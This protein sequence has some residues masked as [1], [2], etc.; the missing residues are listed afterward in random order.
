VLEQLIVVLEQLIEEGSGSGWRAGVC[1]LAEI[2]VALSRSA[3]F[4]SDSDTDPALLTCARI[5]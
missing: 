5:P 1:G 3:E 4:S 2:R